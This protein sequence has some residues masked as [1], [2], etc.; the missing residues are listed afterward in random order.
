VLLDQRL[1]ATV[2][3]VASGA[4]S[5]GRELLEVR[6]VSED[7][8]TLHIYEG[9]LKELPGARLEVGRRYRMV[10]RP[11]VNNRWVELKIEAIR[12]E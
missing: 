4:N 10:L 2:E 12:P 7:G 8:Q 5:L 9:Q 1:E 3:V 11:F 6:L